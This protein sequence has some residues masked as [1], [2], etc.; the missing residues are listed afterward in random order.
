MRRAARAL[1]WGRDPWNLLFAGL[2]AVHLVP[3]W[4]FPYFPSQD[5]P[6]ALNNGNILREYNDPSLPV[7]REYLTISRNPDPS[8]AVHVILAGLMLVLPPLLAEKLLLSGYVVLL[9]LSVRYAIRSVRP[10][11]GFAAV[12][13]FPFIYNYLLHVGFYNFAY[14]LPLFFLVVGGWLRHHR[15]LGLRNG[16][17][18]AALAAVLYFCHIVSL[19]LAVAA[20][21]FLAAWLSLCD[22]ASRNRRRVPWGAALRAAILP[23]IGG[24]AALF[25]PSLGLSLL[26]LAKQGAGV[27]EG[28]YP[29]PYLFQRLVHLDSLLSHTPPER[30]AATAVA[31]LFGLLLAGRLIAKVAPGRFDRWDGLL[32][33]AAFY[34]AVYFLAPEKMSGGAFISFRLNLFPFLALILWLGAQ[35]HGRTSRAAVT[36]AASAIA[37]V[38]LGLHASGYAVLNDHLA[39]YLSGADLVE[40]NSTVLPLCY[41]HYGRGPEGGPLSA[42]IKVF[43]HA[44]GYLGA[45]R[46][47]VD[48]DNYQANATY[49]PTL[50]RPERNPFKH[51]SLTEHGL[52]SLPPCVDVLGYPGKTGG[53]V[54]YVLLWGLDEPMRRHPCTQITLRQLEAGYDLVHTSPQRGQMRLYRRKDLAT[55]A[56]RG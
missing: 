44:A 13:A 20:V 6:V 47:A 34:T 5:G 11:S 31:A 49:F 7:F 41:A 28:H 39:E 17:L 3:V 53:R 29:F 25:A 56:A 14:S 52:E 21:G 30:H 27:T 32:L 35:P 23:R 37:L 55:A 19:A 12:L 18:L 54:D 48:L 15:S 16:A 51:L 36:L 50:W 43:L 22:A 26:F 1:V 45:L 40:P 38:F 10:E 42:R 8:W 46:D 4:A 2:V 24:A 33:I 9:P